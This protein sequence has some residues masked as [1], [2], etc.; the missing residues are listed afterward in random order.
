MYWKGSFKRKDDSSVQEH[1]MYV[2]NILNFEILI[3][4]NKISFY[5]VYDTSLDILMKFD[6]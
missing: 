2:L 6:T 1:H 3:L 4:F 5:N